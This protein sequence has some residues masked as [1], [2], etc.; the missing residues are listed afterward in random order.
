MNFRDTF[1]EKLNSQ[2][3]PKLNSGNYFDPFL[4]V[5][6]Q[7]A[8][9]WIF[10]EIKNKEI[11]ALPVEDLL[12][13]GTLQGILLKIS[14]RVLI[15]D[16]NI[17]KSEG[18]LRGDTEDQEYRDYVFHYL[19]AP[20]YLGKL[21]QRYP[22]WEQSLF[23]ALTFYVR[24]MTEIIEHLSLD[25]ENLNVH[26][27]NENPFRQVRH[28][29]GSGSD[30]HCGNRMVYK[31][32]L[33]NGE[34]LYHKPRINEG[35]SFFSDLYT[36]IG[37]SGGISAYVTPT[38]MGNGYAWE[39]DMA[40]GACM[41][42]QQTKD[43][44]K[45]LGM[46]L[47]ICQLCHTSDMHY[48]NMIAHGEYPMLIDYET[49]VQ[50]PFQPVR[51]DESEMDAAIRMSV[52]TIGLLPFFGM[53]LKKMKADFSGL[54]G[55]GGQE[56]NF[57]VPVIRNPGKSSM[58]IGYVFAKTREQKN[59]VHLNEAVIQPSEYVREIKEGFRL[60]YHYIC[61][62]RPEILECVQQL[63]EGTFRHLFRN[64]QEYQMIL[65]LSYHPEFM[66]EEGKRKAFLA[67]ALSVPGFQDK[68]W[69]IEQEIRDLLN[70]DI[71]YFQFRMSG[72]E[73]LNSEGNAVA[74]YFPVTG[75]DFLK[76]QIESRSVM[77][78][79]LQEQFIEVALNYGRVR[80]LN[81]VKHR[82]TRGNSCDLMELLEK[83]ADA[84]YEKQ[85][86]LQDEVG[87]INTCILPGKDDR[88]FTYHMQTSSMHLY[89]GIMGNAVFFAALLKWM[90]QHKAKGLY[91]HL[92]RQLFAY[93]DSLCKNHEK[94]LETGAF[95]GEGSIVYGY[96]LLYKITGKQVFLEYAE[97]HSEVVYEAAEADHNFDIISGNAGALLV[98]LN[99][100]DITGAEKYLNM[101]KDMAGFLMNQAV[102]AAEGVG[103]KN[104]GN[105]ALLA[106]F[107]HGNSG[108]L[109]AL[110]RLSS[111]TRDAQFLN[112]A[113]RAFL[114]E[115]TLY[116]HEMG[117]WLDLRSD[118]EIYVDD[119]KWCHGTGGILFSRILSEPYFHGK[120]KDVLKADI[121]K[122]RADTPKI[123]LR[124][125]MG[126]CHGN[127]GNLILGSIMDDGSW[128]ETLDSNKREVLKLL[129]SAYN[130]DPT[131]GILYEHYDYGLMTGLSGIGY[132][133]LYSIDPTLP[134]I[135]DAGL[136]RIQ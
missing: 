67:E 54:C 69:I 56:L 122:L 105:G 99:L 78:M 85:V 63:S 60:A 44:F 117:G 84:I 45:R 36:R 7:T 103:W 76:S 15:A 82:N 112:M 129:Q 3:E 4:N 43:Y 19:L 94:T 91:H 133:L 132:S 128:K 73:I 106:G 40:Y 98:F 18:K 31:V 58:Q 23:Q 72:K 130:E 87:W 88:R 92:L 24:N 46:I 131:S 110:A 123:S 55:D 90:P 97:K 52:L 113:W 96:E 89:D 118:E 71:P 39:K 74:P 27:F 70:G 12:N 111:Y 14:K 62:N 13:D 16:M 20:E 30:T 126:L 66:K 42:E 80:W 10:D 25:R 8:R 125:E 136:E 93:T 68:P 86:I 77:D 47:C 6:A 75:M 57:K 53:N 108:I 28:I 120:Q 26:F 65:D 102:P 101:A 49:L 41:T 61:G 109:Y 1:L 22:V 81:D 59:R 104:S 83:T 127:F 17:C 32:E 115:R 79:K 95:I 64:T 35:I 9:T 107:S 121:R 116:K 2:S 134:P 114:Y 21:F 34:V 100:Y 119:F 124:K 33:D 51:S 37:A 29:S 38:F 48:E 11:L 5:L 50:I 135:F